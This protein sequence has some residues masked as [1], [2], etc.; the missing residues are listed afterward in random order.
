MEYQKNLTHFIIHPKGSDLIIAFYNVTV[1]S[2][3]KNHFKKQ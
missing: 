1:N 3:S 2:L